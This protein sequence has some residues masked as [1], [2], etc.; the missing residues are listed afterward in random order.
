VLANDTDPDGDALEVRSVQTSAT[1]GTVTIAPDD[2]SVT[3]DPTGHFDSL[4]PGETA[5]DTCR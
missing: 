3:Y 5:S 4:N 1:Q 2:K